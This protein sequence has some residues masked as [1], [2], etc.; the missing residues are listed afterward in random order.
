LSGDALAIELPNDIRVNLK[1]WNY[2][3]FEGYYNYEWWGPAWV[4]FFLDEKGKV[5]EFDKDGVV[6]RLSEGQPPAKAD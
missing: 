2:D 1:H 5:V 6:Y 4:R 3:T